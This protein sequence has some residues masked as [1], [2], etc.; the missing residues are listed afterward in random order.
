MLPAPP[1]R[2]G[3]SCHAENVRSAAPFAA[4]VFAGLHFEVALAS[5]VVWPWPRFFARHMLAA[6]SAPT[7]A[8]VVC[9]VQ[10]DPTLEAQASRDVAHWERRHADDALLVRSGRVELEIRC[11]PALHYQ[12]Q[13][14]LGSTRDLA[15]CL[16]LVAASVVE[17]AGGLCL[18]ATAVEWAGQAVL[19]L[20]PSGTGKTTAA[21][22]LEPVRCLAYDRV[23]VIP[24]AAADG[25]YEIWALPI[26]TAPMLPLCEAV[27]LPLAALLRVVQARVP[28]LTRLRGAEAT[29]VVRE[30]VEVGVGSGFFEDARLAAVCGLALAANSGRAELVLGQN[31]RAALA[32][33]L[34]EALPLAASEAR[35]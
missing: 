22:Q 1:R 29:L 13:A 33:F 27:S 16:M 14:K 4:F 15:A 17:L 25:G 21:Q 28:R 31:W 34:G 24:N 12:V 32:E 10:L 18:H 11:A 9:S 30:A 23:T 2:N 8:H 19:L 7:L 3:A 20:G 6:G 5:G 35:A 26:G